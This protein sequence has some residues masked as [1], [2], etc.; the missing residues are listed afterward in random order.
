MSS[1][2]NTLTA[3][4]WQDVCVRDNEIQEAGNVEWPQERG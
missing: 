1:V 4:Y 2:L 3:N